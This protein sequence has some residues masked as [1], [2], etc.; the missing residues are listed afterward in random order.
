MKAVQPTHMTALLPVLLI[1]ALAL[2]SGWWYT[3]RYVKATYISHPPIGRFVTVDGTK[4][5]F[6]EEGSGRAVIMI[7]G[8]D[9]TLF[10]FKRSIFDLV[11][12]DFRAVA[13]DRPGHGYSDAPVGESLTI[14]LNARIIREAAQQ[15]GII[16]PTVIGYSYG[17]AVALRWAIDHPDDIGGLVLISPAVY[18]QRHLLRVFAYV[19]GIP[20][21]G[22]LLVHTLFM[23]IAQPQVRLW[24]RRAF[25]PDPLPPDILDS[26]KAFSLRPKQ[27]TAFAEEMRH[28]NRDLSE[29]GS[30]A[31]R[32]TLPVAILAGDGDILLTTTKQAVRLASTLPQ[33]TTKVFLRT[34]HEVHYKYREETIAAIRSVA[35]KVDTNDSGPS[36]EIS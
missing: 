9:G 34:G 32:I 6:I 7:H 14:P 21:L 25:R 15:L 18:P 26:V 23:P 19:A 5:H 10:N 11:A 33:A 8:S 1:A 13:F 29:I 2:V 30:Q 16:K 20:V 36:K 28:F 31:T 35:A 3:R 22:P 27:F 17:G 4:I 24:A 12:R